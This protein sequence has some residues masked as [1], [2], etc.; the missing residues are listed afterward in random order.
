MTTP[1]EDM[2]AAADT[3][4]GELETALEPRIA[5]IGAIEYAI[6]ALTPAV[7]GQE[8]FSKGTLTVVA[9]SV[10]DLATK[11]TEFIEGDAIPTATVIE[12]DESV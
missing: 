6:R 12:D 8:S 4:I 7:A 3:R 9:D 11:I 1:F 5:R 2:M 10:I